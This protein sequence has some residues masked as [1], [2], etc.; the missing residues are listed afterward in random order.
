[1][2]LVYVDDC[3]E[4]SHAP[5]DIMKMVGEEYILKA[6]YGARWVFFRVARALREMDTSCIARKF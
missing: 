2:F 5:I 4:V 1:M 6:G 3:L